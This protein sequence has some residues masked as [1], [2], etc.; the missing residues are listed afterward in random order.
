VDEQSAIKAILI[1]LVIAMAIVAGAMC[2]VMYFVARAAKTAI[3]AA[4]S[5]ATSLERLETL[6]NQQRMGSDKVEQR[7]APSLRP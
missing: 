2:V 4:R 1:G 5:L 3:E 7:P 6:V